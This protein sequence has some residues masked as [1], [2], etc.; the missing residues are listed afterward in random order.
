LVDALEY[1]EPRYDYLIIDTS[2]GISSTVLHFVAAAQMAAV[3]ITPEPTSLTDAFS[4]LKVLGRRGY[5]RSP[6]VIVNMVQ[7]TSKAKIIYGRFEAAVKKYIGL[8]TEFLGAVCMDESIRSSISLQRPV[9]LFAESDPSCKSFYR[10]ADRLD[11]VFNRS[12][13]P[14]L[15]FTTYWKKIV[16]R[17]NK[18]RMNTAMETQAKVSALEN[19]SAVERPLTASVSQQNKDESVRDELVKADIVNVEPL[20][21]SSEDRWVDLKVKL[22]QFLQ[23]DDT[24]P[25]Q[26][27]TLLSSCIFTYGDRLEGAAND[28][29]HCLLQIVDP[30]KLSDEHR[31]LMVQN[32]ERLTLVPKASIVVSPAQTIIQKHRYDEKEFGSQ[33]G[34][35]EKIKQ[36]SG[37]MSLDS[38]LETVKYASLV[39]T[40]SD[41]SY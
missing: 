2:A 35:V 8:N 18:Q 27:T 34:L 38:L 14:K 16:E 36:S 29:L 7:N 13:V 39:D 33:A 5:K 22:N 40:C 4:L 15:S 12:T 17:S 20:D 28:L 3:V 11:T 21:S 31:E 24:T 23:S 41:S 1:L 32:L 19:Q 26:V 25:E 10:L 37:Q 30:S 9:A 6:Q